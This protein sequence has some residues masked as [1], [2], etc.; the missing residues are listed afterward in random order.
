[1]TAW[2]AGQMNSRCPPPLMP[3]APLCRYQKKTLVALDRY[4]NDRFRYPVVIFHS[5]K[6]AQ[7]MSRGQNTTWLDDV[8]RS[9]RSQ[10]IFQEV[11][12][13]YPKYLRPWQTVKIQCPRYRYP[14][15]LNYVHMISFFSL[16][17]FRHPILAEYEY[18]WRL[19]GDL[20]L[21]KPI[22]CDIFQ[23]PAEGPGPSLRTLSLSLSLSLSLLFRTALKDRP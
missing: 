20:A 13:Q 1:M 14:R 15:A 2:P 17:W 10:V 22:P 11:N 3:S 8:R 4:F 16:G 5:P 6:Y 12:F 23:V 9:T 19:D 7:R 21:T 18:V